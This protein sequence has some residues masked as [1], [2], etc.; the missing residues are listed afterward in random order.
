MRDRASYF[1]TDLIEGKDQWP[2]K[3]LLDL[4]YRVERMTPHPRRRNA[5]TR[6]RARSSPGCTTLRMRCGGMAKWPYNTATR[7]RVRAA[8]LLIE[9]LC[10]ACQGWGSRRPASLAGRMDE[11]EGMNGPRN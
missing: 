6:T 7:A 1:L 11:V 4:A 8:H 3:K 9:P 10:R 5:F 2:D